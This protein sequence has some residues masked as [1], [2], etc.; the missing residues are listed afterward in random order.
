MDLPQIV[1]DSLRPRAVSDN[2]LSNGLKYTPGGGTVVIESHRLAGPL[3]TSCP[4]ARFREHSL[5]AVSS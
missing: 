2:I 4:S 1:A 5:T 3:S